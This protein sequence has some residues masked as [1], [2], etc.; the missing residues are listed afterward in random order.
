MASTRKVL[1][2]ESRL[3]VMQI[4]KHNSQVTSRKIAKE[5][6]I[7]NGSAYYLLI[8][9]IDNGF[10]KLLNFEEHSNNIRYSYSLTPK[11]IREKSILTHKFLFYKKIQYEALKNEI[12]QLEQEVE[13]K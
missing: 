1:Q 4:I 10:I 7:S 3:R 6:G 12:R 5:V 8:S 2:E 9:L 11:G 13:N